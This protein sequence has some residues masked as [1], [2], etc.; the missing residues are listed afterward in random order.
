MSGRTASRGQALVEMS[1]VIPMVFILLGVVYTASDAMHSAIGLTSA[2][3]AG[4]IMAASDLSTD[5]SNTTKAVDDATAAINAEENVSFYQKA[6]P[7]CT[8]NCVTLTKTVGSASSIT[9]AQITITHSV[10]TGIPVVSGI[11]ISVK[12]TARYV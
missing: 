4:A 7:G 11:N 1:L 3:R 2:A 12:A 8:N 6:G 10:A 5:S 9:L